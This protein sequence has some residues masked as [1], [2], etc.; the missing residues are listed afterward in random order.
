MKVF[1]QRDGFSM[2]ELMIAI[3]VMS[4]GL[5]SIFG[6]LHRGMDHMKTVGGKNFAVVAVTSEIEMI[7]AM[8]GDELPHTYEGPFLREV[9]L[10]A[11]PNG[12]GALKIEKREGSGG[13]LKK[14]TAT[15]TWTA[16]GRPKSVS[17]STLV[18][19]P[20]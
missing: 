3:A 10:S 4:F 11:L 8:S 5:G 7:K 13:R 16:L 18:G 2:I 15:V 20:R 19:G 1:R 6:V 17:V 9:D 14:V 12:E